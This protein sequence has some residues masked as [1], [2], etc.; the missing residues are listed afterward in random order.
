MKRSVCLILVIMVLLLCVSGCSNI[1]NDADP[2][3]YPYALIDDAGRTITIEEVP[4]RIISFSPAHTETLIA[5]GLLEN[6]V[7]VDDWSNYP[8]A[9][10][11]IEKVGD[12]FSPNYEVIVGL[13]PDLVI[14]V[15][16]A[17][18]SFVSRLDEL[19]IP[20][21]VLQAESLEDIL[22]DMITIGEVCGVQETAHA[23]VQDLQNRMDQVKDMVTTIPED[24]RVSV[25]YEVSPPGVWGLWT[26]GPESY[27]HDMI[28][29]AG[30]KNVSSDTEGDYFSY[31][32][33]VLLEKD[34][35]VI[36][37]PNTETP[38]DI[39]AGLRPAW[40]TMNAVQNGRIY[41]IDADVVSRPG[42][43]IVDALETIAQY[44]YPEYF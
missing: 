13:N 35:Q 2:I 32:E 30:G 9:T 19:G 31:S 10:Q 17:D 12:T 33:E 15:G 34:P 36:I 3:Q 14:T 22:D 21:L 23:L 37:T 41:W 24:Q 29:T 16:S 7:G 25:F 5:F 4:V 44:L 42:P 43:R 27:I 11:G 26:V 28:E 1:D 8:E 39:A 18:T 38:E 40:Q 20:V 6:L